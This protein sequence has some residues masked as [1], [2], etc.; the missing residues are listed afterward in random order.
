M[1]LATQV[2]IVHISPYGGVGEKYKGRAGFG[3][4]YWGILY[5]DGPNMRLTPLIWSIFYQNC[6]GCLR[7]IFLFNDFWIPQ[8]PPNHPPPPPPSKVCKK[9]E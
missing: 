4:E 3:E 8:K 2:Y 1:N 9:I 7:G 5:P 6:Q